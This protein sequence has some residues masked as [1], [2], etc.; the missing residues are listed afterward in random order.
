MRIDEIERQV[1]DQHSTLRAFPSQGPSFE[2]T[3]SAQNQRA[4]VELQI[5]STKLLTDQHQK[6]EKMNES[7]R[8]LSEWAE[9]HQIALQEQGRLE[10]LRHKSNMRYVKIAAWTGV[11]STIF[12]AIA[13]F[14]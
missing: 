5:K 3:F 14:K 6:L 2:P 10:E 11:I 13:I 1:A 12:G 8:L 9:K 4:S 7:L